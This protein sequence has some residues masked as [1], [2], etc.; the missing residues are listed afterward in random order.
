[1][2]AALEEQRT[3]LR[4]EVAS[5]SNQIAAQLEVGENERRLQKTVKE[6]T[7][8]VARSYDRFRAA[9]RGQVATAT[10]DLFRRLA[11]EQEFSGVTI[12]EDY[13]L[14]VL[15]QEHRPLALISSGENQILT[16]A[17]IGALAECSVE[18][19]PMVMDTPFGRLDVGHREGILRWVST[20]DTRSSFSF[21]RARTTPSSMRTCSAERSGVN[22]ASNVSRRSVRK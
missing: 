15:D 12:S 18:D 19:A 7:E 5:L 16:M 3:K 9:M 4:A 17:F 8:I 13:L 22:T 11:T 2:V 20:F 1:M 6:A 10:S 14:S 21:S